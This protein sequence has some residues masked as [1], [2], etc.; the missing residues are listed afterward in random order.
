MGKPLN[1]A[2]QTFGR[3]TAIRRAE[4]D[5]NGRARW[6]CDCECGNST[7]ARSTDLTGGKQLSCGCWRREASGMRGPTY[8]HSRPGHFSR[9]YRSWSGM[10]QRCTNPKNPSYN[11]TVRGIT[12][13]D[14]WLNSFAAFLEDMGECP[15]NEHSIDRINNDGNYEPSNCRWADKWTQARNRR[16]ARRTQ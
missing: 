3:L 14:R 15:D 5:D 9:T 8:E 4:N 10:I 12:V 1:L 7:T 6:L 13:C 2:G 16:P 11:C